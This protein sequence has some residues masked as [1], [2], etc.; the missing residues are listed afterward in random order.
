M[1]NEDED[2]DEDICRCLLKSHGRQFTIKSYEPGVAQNQ[3]SSVLSWS[4]VDSGCTIYMGYWLLRS[5]VR[6]GTADFLYPAVLAMGST[7]FREA[8]PGLG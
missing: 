2:W 7:N 8:L 4:M 6:K 3:L 5:R 1:H